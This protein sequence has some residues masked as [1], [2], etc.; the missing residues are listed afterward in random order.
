[1][2][3]GSMERAR[4]VLFPARLVNDSQDEGLPDQ[5]GSNVVCEM[6]DEEDDAKWRSPLA[7][8]LLPNAYSFC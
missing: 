5:Q 3:F 8:G 7:I 4:P 1:M 2:I 6:E